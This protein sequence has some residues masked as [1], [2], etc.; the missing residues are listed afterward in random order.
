MRGLYVVGSVVCRRLERSSRLS[1]FGS[2]LSALGARL[3][4]LG[5]R[6]SALGS[7]L[8]ALGSRLSDNRLK[9]LGAESKHF[10]CL[11]T[12]EDRQPT[13]GSYHF[14]RLPP[15]PLRM[16]RTGWKSD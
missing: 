9:L 1:A 13:T 4:A 3:S 14:S 8:S 16:K 11:P 12:T 7:R 15:S 5:S 6:L 10:S 2:R